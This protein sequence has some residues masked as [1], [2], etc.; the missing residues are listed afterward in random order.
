MSSV[1][2][3]SALERRLNASIPQQAIRGEVAARLKKIGRTAKISGFRPGKIPAKILEQHYGAQAHQE[4]FGDA[5]QRS[6][7]EAVQLNNLRVAGYPQFEV[8]TN[9]PNADLIEYS[10][11]FEVYPEVQIG[12]LSGVAM[13]HLVYELAQADVDSTVMTLRKQRAV[14]ETADRAAQA[15]DQ[16]LVDFTGKLNGEVFQGGEAKNYSFVLGAGRMLPEFEV[17]LTG[18]KAG[19]TKSFDMT[20]PADYHGKDVAGKQVTFTIALHKVEAPKLPEVD[21]SFAEV[22]G[23]EGGDVSKLESEIRSSLQHEVA[24]RL[25][26]R[27]KEAAMEALLK[28]SSFAVPKALVEWEA[29]SLMQKTA[30]DME[31][32]G[33]KMEGLSI[34]PEFFA[35]RAERRVKLG[36]ILA[37]LAQKQGL[38]ARP[39]QV[40]ALVE[41]YAQSFDQP[42]DVVRWVYANASQLQEVENL[43]M[44]E[45]IVAWTMAQAKTADKAISFNELMGN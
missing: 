9:D 3:V 38:K 18:M 29:Q 33:M 31:S 20:F 8:K 22:V 23:I 27:N 14:F 35:E 25:K 43:V 30:Q 15:D 19:E 24:R 16:V 45:N 36:L 4:A 37:D 28:V 42:E 6:F 21:A 41:D 13:E 44:E 17:A 1:I 40:R 12:D 39:E 5:L 34:S 11:T 26:A 10:A 2:T 32:R 7:A